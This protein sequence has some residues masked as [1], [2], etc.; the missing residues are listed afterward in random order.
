M[1]AGSDSSSDCISCAAGKYS[2][3]S[4]SRG[5]GTYKATC[6]TCSTGRYSI[7][8]QS[9]C[10]SSCPYGYI[11]IT[12][13]PACSSTCPDGYSQTTSG[14]NGISCTQCPAGKLIITI[15]ITNIINITTTR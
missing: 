3:T 8:G 11:Q 7:A 2:A 13:N 15:V 5:R 6:Y 1:T 10:S 14:S 12:G 9:S 4:G